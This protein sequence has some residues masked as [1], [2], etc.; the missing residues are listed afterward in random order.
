ML[1]ECSSSRPSILRRLYQKAK[2]ATYSPAHPVPEGRC[3]HSSTSACCPRPRT[4]DGRF[5]C[6]SDWR[7]LYAM[8]AA[9]LRGRGADSHPCLSLPMPV[10]LSEVYLMHVHGSSLSQ[11][12]FPQ[13]TPTHTCNMRAQGSLDKVLLTKT[14]WCHLCRPAEA[15][16]RLSA[17]AL[18]PR[19][20]GLHAKQLVHA[21]PINTMLP[22]TESDAGRR[23]FQSSRVRTVSSFGSIRFVQDVKL[24]MVAAPF[25][26]RSLLISMHPHD[27]LLVFARPCSHC[28][29]S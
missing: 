17:I 13:F 19:R 6:F 7:F 24:D 2:K 14:L 21:C 8:C 5:A 9:A 25:K 15:Q 4:H 22:C 27:Q 1:S 20:A 29:F 16:I 26:R 11:D 28:V 3:A 18:Q 10:S 23:I 12:V